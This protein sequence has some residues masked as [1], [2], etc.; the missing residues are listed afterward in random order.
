MSKVNNGGPAFPSTT[1]TYVAKDG[2]TMHQGANGMMLRDYF[3]AKAMESL[4]LQQNLYSIDTVEGVE[5][6]AA[7]AYDLADAMLRAR[8]AA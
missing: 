8:G 6:I 1:K 5:A 7:N 3:A 2:D 4:A